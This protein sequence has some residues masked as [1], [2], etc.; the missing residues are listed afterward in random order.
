MGN[1]FQFVARSGI[2]AGR[3]TGL[4]ARLLRRQVERTER[5]QDRAEELQEKGMGIMKTA[6]RSLAFVL[7]IVIIASQEAL[8][9]VPTSLRDGALAVGEAAL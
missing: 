7:P 3:F 8:R 4:S 1:S 5:I 9:A 2:A 6:R